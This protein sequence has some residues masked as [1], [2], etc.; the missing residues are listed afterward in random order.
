[1]RAASSTTGRDC[2]PMPDGCAPRV[3]TPLTPT[4]NCAKFERS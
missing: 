2:W 4:S 3:V 1:M